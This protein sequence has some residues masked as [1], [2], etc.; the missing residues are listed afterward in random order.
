MNVSTFFSLPD[1]KRSIQRPKGAVWPA[2]DSPQRPRQK[3]GP[4]CSSKMWRE[5]DPPEEE[6]ETHSSILAWKI[7]WTEEPGVQN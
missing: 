2:P 3:P 5:G 4:E 6:M 7:P 1:H